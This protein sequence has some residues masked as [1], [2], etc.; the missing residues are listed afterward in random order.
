LNSI[1]TIL[2][3]DDEVLI[4]KAVEEILKIEG[5]NVVKAQSGDE[6]L[7]KLEKIKPDLILLDY[8]MPS[9]S[10]RD[11]CE[12]IRV[13]NKLKNLKIAFLTVAIPSN[14][15]GK[16]EM[17]RLGI[18]DYIQKPFEKKDLVKRVKKIIG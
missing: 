13:Y 9:M 3:V 11:L 10:G 4:L 7:K 17:E 1:K 18:L 12:R 16:E 15:G 14:I 6:A 2:V 5:Y 8:Y